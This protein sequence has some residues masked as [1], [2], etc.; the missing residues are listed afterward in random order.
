MTK[1]FSWR[2]IAEEFAFKFPGIL[3]PCELDGRIWYSQEDGIMLCDLARIS[4][5]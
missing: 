4:Y 1:E 5:D 2:R 3:E